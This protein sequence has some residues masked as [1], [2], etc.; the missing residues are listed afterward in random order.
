[1]DAQFFDDKEITPF[2][3]VNVYQASTINFYDFNLPRGRYLPEKILMGEFSC[4]Y[5][6]SKNLT[7]KI[8]IQFGGS[9]NYLWYNLKIGYPNIQEFYELVIDENRV[10]PSEDIPFNVGKIRV[11]DTNL[12]VPVGVKFFLPKRDSEGSIS[13]SIHHITSVLLR[14]KIKTEI[15]NVIPSSPFT[16]FSFGGGFE[17]VDGTSYEKEINEYFRDEHT[18]VLSRLKLGLGL[19]FRIGKKGSMNLNAYW[20]SHQNS[21]FKKMLESAKGLGGSI[22]FTTP[23]SSENVFV[24]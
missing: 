14:T 12:S 19:N 21:P 16:I 3:G 24:D 20:I 5:I 17:V 10:I 13:F 2:L 23:F 11:G 8:A 18:R 4:E 6:L 7:E 22:S 15:G 9:Y 1:M